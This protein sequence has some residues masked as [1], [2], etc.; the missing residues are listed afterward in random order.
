[1]KSSPHSLLELALEEQQREALC[2]ERIRDVSFLCSR[3]DG[4]VSSQLESEIRWRIACIRT[5]GVI[6]SLSEA[7]P[8]TGCSEIG[9]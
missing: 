3:N 6:E 4:F 7:P 9:T 2:D 8:E 1:M 5:E